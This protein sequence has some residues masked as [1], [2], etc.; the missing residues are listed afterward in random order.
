MN[1]ENVE[2]L[3]RNNV[4]NVKNGLQSQITGKCPF[5]DDTHNSWSGNIENGLWRCHACGK[6]GNAY[7]F[8]ERLNLKP[9][10]YINHN[11]TAKPQNKNISVNT[12]KLFEESYSYMEYLIENIDSLPIPKFWDLRLICDLGIGWDDN[13]K[14][15][16]FSLQDKNG[17]VIN[18]HWHKFISHQLGD[19]K[20]K[21]YPL[22]YIINYDKIK[23]LLICEGEKDCISL[24]SNG[25]Q[26]ATV[27]TGANSVPKIS[28]DINGF[29]EYIIIYDNDKAGRIGSKKI[30]NHIKSNNPNSILNI[31]KWGNDIKGY[32][33]TDSIEEYP[34]L[35]ELDGVLANAEEYS[36]N[37]NVTGRLKMIS[38]I[39]ASNMVVPEVEWIIPGLLP[40]N[41]KCILGGSTGSNKSYFALELSMRI[42]QGHTSFMGYNISETKTTLFV[43]L[44]VG[45][46]ELL[47]RYQR[48]S[49]TLEFKNHKNINLLTRSGGFDDV[50]DEILEIGQVYRPDLIIID[51][52]YSSVGDIDISRNDKI[53]SVLGKIDEI[54]DK[55]GSTI[56]VVHHFNKL[57]NEMGLVSDRMQGGSSLQNWMEYCIL[58]SKTNR[59]DFRL[60]KIVKSRGTIQSEEV[61]GLQ[62]NS[63]TFTLEMIGIVKDWQR[64]IKPYN[65]LKQWEKALS[66]MDENF[67]SK[68][69]INKVVNELSLSRETAF[70][71]L[72]ELQT[73]G[74]I[75]KVKQGVYKKTGLILI[76]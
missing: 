22:P 24:L 40:K 72:R 68:D 32:D 73:N 19:T 9:E 70:L 64:Y 14:R 46:E 34:D 62:W 63:E 5:H 53:K 12:D 4:E 2:Y 41:F 30:A 20:C 37:V 54:K 67:I 29:N 36:I 52:L 15:I 38:G 39:E 11:H 69:W 3:F 13:K 58:L 74:M 23:P 16:T 42:A 65:S 43:D 56:L 28:T 48:I 7:Q 61:Y 51:N 55:T 57:G 59:Q 18:I 33:V 75:E 76:D 26:A 45:E 10:P 6:T 31:G 66:A 44:E 71:W 47:R 25:Y 1:I 21:W 50:Y 49:N 8:A 27:T 35:S 17:D 60:M